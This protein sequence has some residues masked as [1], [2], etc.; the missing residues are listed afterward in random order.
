MFFIEA[1]GIDNYV[2]TGNGFELVDHA[3]QQYVWEDETEAREQLERAL[4]VAEEWEAIGYV[5]LYVIEDDGSEQ[6]LEWYT[7]EDK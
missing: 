4:D 6:L 2:W 1:C 7:F 5:S 3:S